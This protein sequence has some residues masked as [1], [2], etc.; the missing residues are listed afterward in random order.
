MS[1]KSHMKNGSAL[2]S[3][4]TAAK[5]AGLGEPAPEVPQSDTMEGIAIETAIAPGGTGVLIRLTNTAANEQGGNDSL[6]GV[7]SVQQTREFCQNILRMCDLIMQPH[8]PQRSLLLVTPAAMWIQ[9]QQMIIRDVG[10]GNFHAQWAIDPKRV[11]A[12]K[13]KLI[14]PAGFG[15]GNF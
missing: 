13:S 7:L 2:G 4:P 11:N 15:S 14:L 6:T 9:G 5:I 12:A 10:D 3:L 1:L 8:Q